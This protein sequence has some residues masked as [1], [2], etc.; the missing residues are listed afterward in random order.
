M[1][2]MRFR[3]FSGLLVAFALAA[4]TS[5][6]KSFNNVNPPASVKPAD[7][8]TE[9]QRLRDII[10]F[11]AKPGRGGLSGLREVIAAPSFRLLDVEDQFQ[12]LTLAAGGTTTAEL[13]LAQSYL[14]RAIALPGIGFEDL[15][16]TFRTSVNAGYA[17]GAFRSLTS[18]AKQWPERL[19]KD[20]DAT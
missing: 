19:K 15:E 6:P 2:P 17:T 3:A 11:H 12:A 7:L 9:R 8:D 10:V 20:M 16:I 4:C 18:L 1:A 5:S 13:K 14:D